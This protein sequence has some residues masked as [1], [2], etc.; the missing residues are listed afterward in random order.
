M[1][2]FT[3]HE[4][5]QRLTDLQYRVT[6][7]GGTERAFTGEYWDT[8]ADGS[9]RCRVCDAELFSSRAKFDSGSGWPSFVEEASEGAVR[10]LED[11]SL[12]MR[13]IEA[14][15]AGCDAHLGHVFPDGPHPTGERYC[16]NSASLRLET[17]GP[18]AGE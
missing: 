3:D 15:C 13:R 12:G 8:R 7:E 1:T 4:I 2:R 18:S 17:E 9:Y 11:R 6:Q 5:R 10:R 16:M 14:R